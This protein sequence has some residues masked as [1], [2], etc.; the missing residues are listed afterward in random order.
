MQNCKY[1]KCHGNNANNNLVLGIKW[2][3]DKAGTTKHT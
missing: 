2:L 1:P 3:F